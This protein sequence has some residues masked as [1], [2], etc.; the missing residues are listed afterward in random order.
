[1]RQSEIDTCLLS[2]FIDSEEGA[3][4]SLWGKLRS[5][6]EV[7]IKL[8]QKVKL[9]VGKSEVRQDEIDSS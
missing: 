8:Y 4:S 7:R 6:Y 9:T 5:K 3:Y 1:M 2:F